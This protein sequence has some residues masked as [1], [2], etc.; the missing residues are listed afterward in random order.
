V[1]KWSHF[2]AGTEEAILPLSSVMAIVSTPR[3]TAKMSGHYVSSVP[4][5][6]ASFFQRLKKVTGNADFWK[7]KA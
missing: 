1:K 4:E 7:P 2:L 5:Y 6:A 3:H